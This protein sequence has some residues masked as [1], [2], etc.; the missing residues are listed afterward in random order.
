[1]SAPLPI[2]VVGGGREGLRQAA[3]IRA[4]ARLRLVAVVSPS[5]EGRER[6]ESLGLPAVAEIEELPE[7]AAGAVIALP[8]SSRVSAAEAAA[9]LG[10]PLLLIG[11]LGAS[12][13]DSRRIIAAAD[14]GGIPLLAGHA[15]R[16]HP[17]AA[18]AREAA[19]GGLLG[20]LIAADAVWHLR[21]P[22][23]SRPYPLRVQSGEGPVLDRLLHD[24]DLLRW[25]LGEAGEVAA[26]SAGGGIST[27][28]SVAAAVIRFEKGALATAILSET[29]L[30]PWGWEASTG[31]AED[32]AGSGQDCLR[33]VGSEGSMSLPSLSYWRHGG[34]GK[35]DRGTALTRLAL[36]CPPTDPL[37]AQIAHFARVVAGEAEPLVPGCDALRSLALALSIEES[38]RRGAIM[39][40]DPERP[41]IWEPTAAAIFRD[42]SGH[43]TGA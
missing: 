33:L 7:E 9:A 12:L 43:S 35:G 15:R 10:L 17:A 25:L 30:S 14:M 37:A 26:M 11:G 32:I 36:P 21:R 41:G 27:G 4:D 28:P 20:E 16:H 5:E 42:L 13:R 23:T 3:L 40:P 38:A 1:M 18:A 2:V 6:L 22:A 24:V 39:V 8:S 31:E 34:A 29:G 19:Q